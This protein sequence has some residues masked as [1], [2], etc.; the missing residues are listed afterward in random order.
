MRTKCL[1]SQFSG[2]I[3]FPIFLITQLIVG[4]NAQSDS[5]CEIARFYVPGIESNY[6]EGFKPELLETIYNYCKD[7]IYKEATDSPRENK[8]GIFDLEITDVSKNIQIKLNDIFCREYGICDSLLAPKSAN[9]ILFG[10]IRYFDLTREVQIVLKVQSLQNGDI[11][12]FGKSSKIQM[13]KFED[14]EDRLMLAREAYDDC[15]KKGKLKAILKKLPDP[16][17]SYIANPPWY[18]H[19]VPGWHPLSQGAKTEGYVLIG[20]QAV[21]WATSAHFINLY[22]KHERDWRAATSASEKE[23]YKEKMDRDA[24]LAWSF[25]L[26]G[27]GLVS[28]LDLVIKAPIQ[29]DAQFSLA[30]ANSGMGL[31]LAYYF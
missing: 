4:A 13:Q 30:P 18:K 8:V 11:I 29:R 7:K 27:Y 15:F 3:I 6:S 12:G 26:G 31:S 20:T 22:N 9:V 2:K 24:V 28:I 5:P 21:L 16:C 23:E 17:S 10:F 1:F 19:L 25:G 14:E